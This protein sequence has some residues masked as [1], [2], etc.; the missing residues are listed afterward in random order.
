MFAI[1]P[2]LKTAVARGFPPK[3]MYPLLTKCD[4]RPM[5]RSLGKRRET[6]AKDFNIAVI[7]MRLPLSIC[8]TDGLSL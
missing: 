5:P 6:E 1:V 2:F 3:R 4:A 8:F 7:S